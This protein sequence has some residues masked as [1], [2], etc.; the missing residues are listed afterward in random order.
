[1]TNYNTEKEVWKDIKGY[2]GI[3]KV[4]NFGKVY[5]LPRPKTK[6][7]LLKPQINKGYERVTLLKEKKIETFSVHR[8]VASHFIEN[9]NKYEVINHIDENKANNSVGNLEWCT[10]AE[11]LQKF[12]GKG[13]ILQYDLNNKLVKI[14]N[15]S[16]EAQN[17]G[18][19]D[20]S[21]IIKC[22]KGKRKTHKKSVWKYETP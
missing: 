5:S 10:Q 7:G 4:S 8:L 12:T 15:S 20:S 2:E 14:W 6:G 16:L 22:C 17:T 11:N 3:Y 19:Y 18:K 13:K 1:M 9:P 21:A